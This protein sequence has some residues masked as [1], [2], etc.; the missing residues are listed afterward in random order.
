MVDRQPMSD[1]GFNEEQLRYDLIDVTGSELQR[2]AQ[3]T[4]TQIKSQLLSIEA[5]ADG[6]DEVSRRVVVIE[7]AVTQIDQAIVTVANDAR[8][9]ARRLSEVTSAMAT[10]EREFKAVT[11][12]L[13]TINSIA[14]QTNL[15]ALNATIE[16]TRAGEA[17]AGFLVVADEVK[18]L[19][20][21]TKKTNEDVQRTVA[22]ITDSIGDLAGSL[23]ETSVA[24]STTLDNVSS[25]QANISTINHQTS[26]FG[27]TIRANIEKFR[28]LSDQTS[29]V[30]NDVR[31]LVVIG[32]TFTFLLEM[33][34]V[35]GLF[36]GSGNPIDRLVPLV[37]A[38]EFSDRTR[39]TDPASDETVLTE[40]DVLISATDPKG[41]ITFANSRFMSVAEYDQGELVGKPHNVIRHNDMPKTAFAD[42]W[43]VIKAGHLWLGIVKNKTKTDGYYWVK[44]MVFPCYQDG[45]IVGYISVRRKP[46]RVEIESAIEAYRLLV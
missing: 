36:E 21:T 10:L 7:D 17:G 19:S 45:A 24:I 8:D 33:M 2:V 18:E 43:E 44:A 46:S 42:L 9:N 35:H 40:D 30:D 12:L 6:F 29:A 41:R 15:L 25:S 31:E 26:D 3:H 1:T 16:A 20:K 39:F 32:E 38:S 23:D 5:S 13:R 37:E 4:T 22:R 28:K 27:R 14:D 34:N 11:N